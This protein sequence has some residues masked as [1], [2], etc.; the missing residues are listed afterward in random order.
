MLRRSLILSPATRSTPT[1]D[2]AAARAA[3]NAG[4]DCVWV[5]ERAPQDAPARV[6]ALAAATAGIDL[7]L[8]VTLDSRGHAHLDETLRT[9]TL[10]AAGRVRMTV[11]VPSTPAASVRPA[12]EQ[13][14]AE[15]APLVHRASVPLGV[16]VG[17]VATALSAA[18]HAD[19]LAVRGADATLVGD[20][21][22]AVGRLNDPPALEVWLDLALDAYDRDD[23]N[24]RSGIDAVRPL[25]AERLA[26]PGV[27]GHH[28][29]RGVARRLGPA[30]LI[31][32]VEAAYA[33]GVPARAAEIVPD[34]LVRATCLVGSVEDVR[35]ALA[36]H[37]SA[38]ASEVAVIVHAPDAS[39]R[40]SVITAFAQEAPGRRADGSGDGPPSSDA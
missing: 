36:R 4:F 25:V 2:L 5:G 20:I 17:D 14:L 32:D 7:G 29:A 26:V 33:R 38:G 34:E 23:P 27:P 28:T 9:L 11:A 1:A 10:L 18:P 12:W 8:G 39:S 24:D 6:A 13:R 40:A 21:A 15:I 37:E 19:R 30:G 16:L 35:A 3:S 31:G 22:A